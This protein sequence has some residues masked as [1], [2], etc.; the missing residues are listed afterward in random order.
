MD[1]GLMRHRV[2]IR[3]VANERNSFGEIEEEPCTVTSV[4][5]SIQ[6]LSGREFIVGMQ[7][8]SEVTHKITIRYNAAVKPSM[9]V[10]NGT[11]CF[12]VLHI[13]DTWER[14]HE[15][16]LMCREVTA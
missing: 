11:R 2:D 15:M 8:H 6:P 4:R 7:Q 3:T 9:T 14:H 1:A 12:H 10:W 5:A 13:V 16:V